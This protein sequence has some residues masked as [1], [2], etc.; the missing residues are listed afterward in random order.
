VTEKIATS[1]LGTRGP[2]WRG[3][4]AAVLGFL[5]L[6]QL[7]PYRAQ[8]QW[9]SD[10]FQV[11][12]LAF[13]V[14]GCVRAARAARAYARTFWSLLATGVLSW[15]GG[16]LLWMFN[17]E[18]FHSASL[19]ALS[20][21]FFLFSALPVILAC[22]VRPDRAQPGG[23]RLAL[24]LG[25]V[26]VLACFLYGYFVL[27]P[28][29]GGDAK[30]YQF[31]LRYLSDFRALL[32][33]GAAVWLSRTSGPPWRPV[34]DR[35]AVSL[36][37]W[38]VGGRIADHAIIAGVYGAGLLDLG[39]TLPLLWIGLTA[40]DWTRSPLALG[41]GPEPAAPDWRGVRRTTVLTA[42]ALVAIPT[43]HFVMFTVEEPAVGLR[44][45]R[46]LVTLVTLGASAAMFLVRQLHLLR[47]VQDAQARRENEIRILFQENPRPM[48]VYDA[49]TLRFVEVNGAA[50]ERYGY[51]REEFLDLRIT[52]IRSPEDA[53][54][55]LDML[56]LLRQ[57][58]E[59]Y[60]FSGEWTHLGRSG[61]RIEVEVASRDLTFRDRRATLVAVT[62]IT[63]QTRF[64]K[65]L[66]QSEERFEKAFQASPAAISISAMADGRYIDVNARFEEV[67]GRS[68]GEVVGKS[69]IELGFW[70]D[71]RVRVQM[72][73]AMEG[74]GYLRN[75]PFAFRRRNGEIRQ[76]LGAFERIQVAGEDCVLA[77]TEDVTERLDLEE[78]LRQSEKLE[79]I[80][81]LAGGIAHDFNNLLG[82]V[83]G[84]S[85]LLARRLADDPRSQKQLGAIRRATERATDLT[86]QL[87]AYGRMQA[88]FP[89][90]LALGKV[91]EE[92]HPML[93]RLLGEQVTLHTLVEPGIGFVRADRGQIEHVLVNLA[94]NAR[95]GMP[96]GGTIRIGCRNQEDPA[97]T[98]LGWV[99][100]RVED[101][102]QGLDAAARERVFEPSFGRNGGPGEVASLGLASVYGIVKQS[103]GEILIESEP[104]RGSVFVIKLP[105]VSPIPAA[106]PGPNP[107]GGRP[108]RT[109]L[110]VDDQEMVR[111]MTRSVLD[112]A[113]YE[114]L[115][116]ADG[117]EA[118]RVSERFSGA[119]DLV[120]TDVI[121]PG[122]SGPETVK[123]VRAGRPGTRVIFIS[124]YTAD[125]LGDRSALGAGTRFLQKPFKPDDL[126]AAVRGVL[127][128]G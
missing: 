61:E 42:V 91:V 43:F 63:E 97:G 3:A 44:G 78:R 89:E 62:D 115:I 32:V 114:V 75:W 13:A 85:E 86:R 35:I 74:A 64:Q 14:A 126:T 5:A 48:W 124:G 15:L 128:E 111:E 11:V 88:L 66:L 113:G 83:L 51:S 20:E 58:Q 23:P 50:V 123:R 81:R 93:N 2:R 104:G 39:W 118:L 82:V 73:E 6:L 22:G 100:L 8:A 70:A 90:V 57:Q 69:A 19:P 80:G 1:D 99:E 49:E 33:V 95:D 105:R 17:E 96:E 25:L 46:G 68:R 12:L 79:A 38:F 98:S 54:R 21:F 7:W 34:Y 53:N 29:M 18:A 117:E 16:Q 103:G 24:D 52:D 4:S 59:K 60:R 31:W 55:L 92:A 27:A 37:F 76:A 77:I 47:G 72:V 45:W 65:A 101:E 9:A 127:G 120:I 109:I 87:L 119:I 36:S 67:T 10:V 110:L 71:P 40:L 122:L 41:P 121:M 107:A 102:G 94:L 28:F 108:G 30:S 26:S 106:G 84:Y 116:A 112:E 56:P 125:A